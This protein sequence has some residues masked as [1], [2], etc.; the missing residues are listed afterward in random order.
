MLVKL[1]CHKSVQR[2]LLIT[3]IGLG[4]S[5]AATASTGLQPVARPL[6]LAQKRPTPPNSPPPNN[7]IHPGGGLSEVT[8]TCPSTAQPLTSLIP[9]SNPVVTTAGQPTVLFYNPYGGNLVGEFSLVTQDHK[10]RIGKIQFTLPDQPGIV[11]VA[12]PDT[13]EN[14]L[15]RDRYYK[16]YLQL[17]CGDDSRPDVELHGWVLTASATPERQQQITEASPAVWYDAIALVFEQLRLHPNDPHRQN[18]WLNLLQKIDADALAHE[19]LRGEV[20]P[21]NTEAEVNNAD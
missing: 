12:L 16:W 21:L 17:Y 13:P 10:Q 4:C 15:D 7:P 8:A 19:P 14:R 3:L 20:I 2:L 5:T 18:Q 11:S 1:R 9:A 6:L